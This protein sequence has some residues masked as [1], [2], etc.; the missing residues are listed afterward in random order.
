MSVVYVHTVA[1]MGTV[2]TVQ[3]VDRRQHA[4]GFDPAADAER[5]LEWFRRV[6]AACTRFDPLSEVSR[7][8]SQVGTPIPVSSILF[9]AVQF[10]LSVAEASGG[11]F[12]P[13]LGAN[14]EQLGFNREY[15]SGQT[16]ESGYAADARTSYRDVH[17]DVAAQTILLDRPLLLD[18]GAVAKGL[19][20]DL[21]AR[22]LG[23]LEHFAIDAGGDLFLAGRNAD[24]EPWTV[25]IRHPRNEREILETITVSDAAVCT[26]GDYERRGP[27]GHHLLDPRTRRPVEH[28]A[29]VTVVAPTAMSADALGTA[30][31]V[32]GPAEG[33][34]FLERHGV[35]GFLVTPTLERHFTS[36]LGRDSHPGASLV[37]H[38][39]RA[40]LL[41]HA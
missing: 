6:E 29:S 41:P 39:G 33:L 18:L 14:L 37:P 38:R 8:A 40:A 36:T 13:T 7:L 35:D 24:D 27:R 26:S 20:I 19:A 10:A 17:V 1:L 31:F 12:D 22:E 3:I 4:D 2:V 30:A 21:A 9:E 15:R 11:A 16:V 34:R 32:L 5:A 23:P 28:V 25:G